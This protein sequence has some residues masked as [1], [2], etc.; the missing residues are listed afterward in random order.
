MSKFSLDVLKRHVYPFTIQEKKDPDVVLGS[1]FGEDVAVTR[2][3]NDV[4]SP[5]RGSNSWVF[6]RGAL[7]TRALAIYPYIRMIN[8]E[9]RRSS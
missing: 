9:K 1:T 2:I 7:L 3:G 5:P 6:G 4:L 8:S